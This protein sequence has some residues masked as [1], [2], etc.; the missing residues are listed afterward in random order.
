MVFFF[1]TRTDIR[2]RHLVVGEHILSSLRALFV[3]A[4]PLVVLLQGCSSSLDVND[5]NRK[6]IPLDPPN[7]LEHRITP[8]S[9]S[10]QLYLAY[11]WDNLKVPLTPL[12][13]T[14]HVR[15]DTGTTPPLLWVKFSG[16]F[17]DTITMG[18]KI[19]PKP[20]YKIVSL[21]LQMDS[22][23]SQRLYECQ[24]EPS[25]GAGTLVQLLNIDPNTTDPNPI[26]IIPPYVPT[27]IHSIATLSFSYL[28]PSSGQP[29]KIVA[30]YKFTATLFDPVEQQTITVPVEGTLT[31]YYH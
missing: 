18:K 23:Y 16:I 7:T 15:I 24:G 20:K 30:T 5:G 25:E 8:D 31:A 19:T 27:T 14:L 21:Q 17:D 12:T 4:I 1:Q 3:L 9:T 22:L 6:E 2:H 10:F 13:Q 29:K 26:T 28:P 11:T